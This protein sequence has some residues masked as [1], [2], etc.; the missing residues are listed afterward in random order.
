MTYR[1][2]KY[3]FNERFKEGPMSNE[4]LRHALNAAIKKA[5]IRKEGNM[6]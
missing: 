2:K 4:G 5:G 1:P 3:L 6:Y